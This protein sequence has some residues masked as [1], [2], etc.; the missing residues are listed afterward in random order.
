[1][2]PLN[3]STRLLLIDDD[4]SMVAGTVST[5]HGLQVAHGA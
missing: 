1:M 2:H 3:H 4:P 5:R